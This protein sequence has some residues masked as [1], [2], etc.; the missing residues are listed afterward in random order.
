V[1]FIEETIDG[2]ASPSDLKIR[3]GF[4][5]PE[6]LP[7][8]SDRD[9]VEVS[10]LEH[11]EFLLADADARAELLLSQPCAPAECPKQATRPDVIHRRR[12]TLRPSPTVIVALGMPIPASHQQVWLKSA[13]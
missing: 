6:D 12:V 1:P 3:A 9:P 5:T 2:A 7:D 13:V 8:R 4:E 11:R 10:A